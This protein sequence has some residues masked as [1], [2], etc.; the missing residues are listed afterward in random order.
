[1]RRGRSP[2]YLVRRAECF[3]QLARTANAELKKK[4]LEL[5]LEDYDAALECD[6]DEP[7][8]LAG[9]GRIYAEMNQYERALTDFEQAVANG[10]GDDRPLLL[11]KARLHA[12]EGGVTARPQ[13]GTDRLPSVVVD[14]KKLNKPQLEKA[15]A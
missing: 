1:E 15:L 7:T 4:N 5:A 13:R 11:E 10:K 9:R 8:V 2:E 12:M 14:K 6:G 3:H